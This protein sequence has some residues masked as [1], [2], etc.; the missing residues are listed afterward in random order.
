MDLDNDNNNVFILDQRHIIK[1]IYNYL[2]K[3]FEDTNINPNIL[4]TCVYYF[5]KSI[6]I[7][8]FNSYSSL[9]NNFI[10]KIQYILVQIDKK[11]NIINK[12][13][14]MK[15]SE[16]I[17]NKKIK[18]N[19]SDNNLRIYK[20]ITQKPT[21]RIFIKNESSEKLNSFAFEFYRKSFL[22]KSFLIF[23]KLINDCFDF[24]LEADRKKISEIIN[25]DKVIFAL[26]F[27]K[28]KLDLRT[29]LL[30]LSRKLL[31]DIKYSNKDNYLYTKIFINNKDSLKDL[32]NNPLINNMEY[33]TK[34]LS[35]LKN[36]Y[37]VTAKCVLKEK[38][39]KK[40]KI[41]DDK[42]KDIKL[43]NY[44]QKKKK[45]SNNR[46][47]STDKKINQINN[48]NLNGNTSNIKSEQ[49]YNNKKILKLENIN[50]NSGEE[51]EKTMSTK[52]Y[53]DEHEFK[54]YEIDIENEKSFMDS[55][56]SFDTSPK[57]NSKNN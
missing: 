30:R 17:F 29:E 52:K 31:I 41:S 38:I 14:N 55:N 5:L 18:N 22:Q 9:F 7:T 56:R 25:I 35:F 3:L 39:L 50:I 53:I 32:K 51:E 24:S 43:S 1:R 44:L 11:Y 19:K 2:E 23:I 12:F 36:F 8:V 42:I 47:D 48:N 33:P 49:R 45:D 37:N 16:L 6:E 46:Y 20:D 27:Y 10:Y 4:L 34:L 57:E 15:D 26:H 21:K 54:E 40:I 28:L 13:F